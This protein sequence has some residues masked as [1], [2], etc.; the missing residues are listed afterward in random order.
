MN[1]VFFSKSKGYH[2]Y[3]YPDEDLGDNAYGPRYYGINYPDETDI[4]NYGKALEKGE[5]PIV[6]GKPAGPGYGI[7]IH[8]NNDEDSIG[9]L[10]SS[11]CIRMYNRDIIDLEKY[12]MLSTPV[13]IFHK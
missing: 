9:H 12:I 4:R 1:K 8:G 2:K 3:G 13:L 10:C 5:I 7:A 6:N 11:G